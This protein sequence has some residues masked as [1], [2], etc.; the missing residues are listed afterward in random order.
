MV[1]N[2]PRVEVTISLSPEEAAVVSEALKYAQLNK[3]R[4]SAPKSVTEQS[5][6]LITSVQMKLSDAARLADG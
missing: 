1:S 5:V 3:E 6:A 2:R 4:G